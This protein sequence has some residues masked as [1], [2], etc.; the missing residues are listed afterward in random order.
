M[1]KKIETLETS[2]FTLEDCLCR[3]LQRAGRSIGRV[4]DDAFRPLDL[5]NWQ[6]SLLVQAHQPEPL[7]I[8]Q[9]AAELA[10]DRTTVTANLK[11]L[12]RRKLLKVV[13]DEEDARARRVVLTNAGRALIAKAA[14][15][16]KTV[17]DEVTR[18]VR[19]V[20]VESL[21]SALEGLV[22]R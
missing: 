10:T 13:V 3:R 12:E 5:T 21:H 14:P 17:N 9:L 16:W 19:G 6:F 8:G 20:D 15:I 7:T 1:I 18:R 2:E 4:F 22:D 11:P